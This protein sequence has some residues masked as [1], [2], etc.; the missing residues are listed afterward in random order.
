MA[1]TSDIALETL[2]PLQLYAIARGVNTALVIVVVVALAGRPWRW[3]TVP[4]AGRPGHRPRSSGRSSWPV[5]STCSGLMAFAIGLQSAPTWMVGLAA[6]FGPAVTILAAVVLLGERLKT[7]QWFGLAGI[8]L[9]MVLI[10][11]P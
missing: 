4:K 6:S 2:S 9:G 3:A 1:I 5:R 11:I 10:A 7:V 8:A